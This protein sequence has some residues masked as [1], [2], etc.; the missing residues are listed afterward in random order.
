MTAIPCPRCPRRN[1]P[2]GA[3]LDALLAE[4]I[5]AIPDDQRADEAVVLGRLARCRDCPWL[6]DATCGLCGC[7]VAYRAAKKLQRCPDSPERWPL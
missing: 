4:W 6:S 2:E 7:Y 1:A 5:D 3:A